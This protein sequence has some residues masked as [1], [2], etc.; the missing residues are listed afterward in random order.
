MVSHVWMSHVW[1]QGNGRTSG[2]PT[3]EGGE[4]DATTIGRN[5]PSCRQSRVPCDRGAA[6]APSEG[7]LADAGELIVPVIVI[8]AG[9]R[10]EGSGGAPVP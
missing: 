9:A 6:G 7:A 4:R 2:F 5:D 10:L 3:P 8:E 1:D